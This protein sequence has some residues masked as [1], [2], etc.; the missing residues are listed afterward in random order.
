[1][2][3]RRHW[4]FIVRDP[5]GYVIQNALVFVYQPNT[6]TNFSGSAFDAVTAGNAL[7]NPFTTN[8]QGE[9][10]GWFTASQDVDVFVTD[11]SGTAYRAVD[12]SGEPAPFTSFTE[13]DEILPDY[14][15]INVTVPG[16]AGE[17]TAAIINPFT[18]QTAV[19]GSVGKYADVAHAHPYTALTPAAPVSRQSVASAGTLLNPSRSDHIHPV[20]AALGKTSKFTN[21]LDTTEQLIHSKTITANTVAAGSMF[22][23]V[24]KGFHSVGTTATTFTFRVRW[25][26]LAGT[27]VFSI[28]FLSLT[29]TH[30]DNP[31]HMEFLLTVQ[32]IGATGTITCGV[33]GDECITT[34][35][36]NTPKLILDVQ[37]AAVTIDTTADKD[38]VLTAQMSQTVGSPNI[39]VDNVLI[40]QVA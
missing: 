31:H 17:L 14:A 39:E 3:A 21:T 32:S 10:E 1:L 2:A 13:K 26:G 18:A 15:D 37:A 20:G 6:T 4:R 11:N 35:V 34:A 24:F 33:S 9:V 28:A 16:V 40:E 30:T 27:Q 22:R 29:T 19:A 38:L 7:T 25:G 5:Y 8:A 12:G 23:I 36:A